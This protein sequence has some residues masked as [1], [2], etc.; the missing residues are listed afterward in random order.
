MMPQSV[1]LHQQKMYF[2]FQHIGWQRNVQMYVCIL[3]GNYNYTQHELQLQGNS[4]NAHEN[5]I[6]NSF[7]N[8][9]TYKICY[10]TFSLY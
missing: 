7:T 6:K 3:T 8:I 4:I 5:V 10:D 9:Y 2:L 1:S